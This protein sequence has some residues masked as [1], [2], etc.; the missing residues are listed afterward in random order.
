M[1]TIICERSAQFSPDEVLVAIAS[2]VY[3]EI[4]YTRSYDVFLE[5]VKDVWIYRG[6]NKN[7]NTVCNI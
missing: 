7:E 5:F 2:E 6:G 1:Y 3:D 4:D